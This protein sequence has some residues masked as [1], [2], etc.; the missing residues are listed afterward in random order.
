MG[1]LCPP[2]SFD[3][4]LSVISDVNRLKVGRLIVAGSEIVVWLECGEI[5]LAE[6]GV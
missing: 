2:A 4:Y 3:W 1:S 5:V 6:S